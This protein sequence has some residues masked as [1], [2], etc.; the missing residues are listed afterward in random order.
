LFALI[1]PF[2]KKGFSPAVA[3]KKDR[4]NKK[5]KVKRFNEFAESG[6]FL[7]TVED[8]RCIIAVE[9]LIFAF[10]SILN[11]Y[12]DGEP[13]YGHPPIKCW[14]NARSDFKERACGFRI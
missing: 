12:A 13:Y 2:V 4:P 10:L 6:V 1:T 11:S 7:L 8:R 9:I 14:N 3:F 5:I